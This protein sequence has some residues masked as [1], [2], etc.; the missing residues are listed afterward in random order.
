MMTG[1]ANPQ[2]RSRRIANPP[3]RKDYGEEKKPKK[4]LPETE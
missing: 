1:I 4:I 2:V 3:E